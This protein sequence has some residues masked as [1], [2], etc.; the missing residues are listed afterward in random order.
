M[1]AL[2]EHFAGRWNHLMAQK[3]GKNKRIGRVA[4]THVSA[5]R[6]SELPLTLTLSPHAGRG[7]HC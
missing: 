5:F 3:C 4:R 1:A 6:C 7:E 2:L